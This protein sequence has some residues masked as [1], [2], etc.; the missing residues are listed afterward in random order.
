MKKRII[1]NSVF[2]LV[3]TVAYITLKAASSKQVNHP[4]DLLL[5]ENVEA[6]SSNGEGEC[7]K[8]FY[9][10]CY[11]SK[12][13]NKGTGC[14]SNGNGSKCATLDTRKLPMPKCSDYNNKCN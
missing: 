7:E 3:V 14:T 6:L 11:C 5:N 1:I 2:F 13:Y 8:D 9:F 10:R 12:W 4:I